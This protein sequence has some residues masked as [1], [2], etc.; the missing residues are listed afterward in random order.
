MPESLIRPFTGLR[1]ATDRAAEVAAPP[2]DVLSTEEARERARGMRWSF[3]HVSKPEIDFAQGT[4]P[5]SPA[6][7]DKAATNLRD[8]IA[9]G[10]LIRDDQP[11]LYV[12]RL[13]AGG[14]VQTGI[15]AVA[16]VAA[17]DSNRIRKHELTRP[18][19]EDDR[20]RQIDALNAQTGPVLL[21]YPEAAEVD[22]ILAGLARGE[23]DC[24]VVAE[25]GVRHS[26]WVVRDG[27]TI[28]ELITQF[29]AM[30]ALYIAD[31]HHR[32]AAASRV[33]AIRRK[34]NA[35]PTG[36]EDYNYFLVVAF[37]Q[38]EMRILPY[39]RL[40]RDLNGLSSDELLQRI[41]ERFRIE[42]RFDPVDPATPNTFGLY[43]E[44]N[45]YH[46]A[47]RPE[48]V[49]KDD[50]IARLDV[51]LLGDNLLAPVLGITDPRTDN[52]I[53][54]V[55]GVRGLSELERRVD[56]GAMACAISMHATRM[57]DL[58]AV[59]DAHDV[60]PPK[61]T[62]FEPKLADGLVSHQLD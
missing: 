18:D 58:M 20:V 32:S 1:P 19:K 45:W 53:D 50:P 9:Q 15:V 31:G 24:D 37:P 39:N 14:I 48:F 41:G 49:R 13:A 44:G 40:V 36:D 43:V 3:L 5:Y 30:P 38:N 27:N 55:G 17:Y 51:S 34:N 4:D 35:A 61:S 25:D 62:W 28:D 52:R 22:A 59:A 47:L 60:M 57:T 12:Y 7:Y 8:M 26:I 21:A 2:Y 10:I 33:A 16:S 6:V 29:N 46:L 11:N 23:P 54:F 56:S 42:K